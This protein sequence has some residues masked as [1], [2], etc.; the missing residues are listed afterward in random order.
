LVKE[1]ASMTESEYLKCQDPQPMLEHLRGRVSD[2]KL[3]LFCCACV[4]RI[5]RHVTDKR[6]RR[7]V[8][9]TELLLAGKLSSDPLRGAAS[10]DISQDQSDSV[11]VHTGASYAAYVATVDDTKEDEIARADDVS[12]M[13]A[14]V[15]ARAAT[16]NPRAKPDPA[17][18]RA[19]ADLLREILGNPFRPRRSSRS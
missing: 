3:R 17:E 4:R 16:G 5:W 14:R 9:L 8:K 2:H 12:E 19:Q 13:A 11:G 6:S 1:E 10:L 15:V 18:R 7:A